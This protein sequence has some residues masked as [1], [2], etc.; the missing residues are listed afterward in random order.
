VVGLHYLPSGHIASAE[1]AKKFPKHGLHSKMHHSAAFRC[2]AFYIIGESFCKRG[3]N[4]D[5]FW[6]D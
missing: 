5:I 6:V 1:P 4:L 2:A 3:E